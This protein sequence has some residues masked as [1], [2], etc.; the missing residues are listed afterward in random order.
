MDIR[1]TCVATAMV[2]GLAP[3]A[4]QDRHEGKADILYSFTGGTDG[5]GSFGGLVMDDHGNLYGTTAA[6]GIATCASPIDAPGCGVVFE[7]SPPAG[8]NG[9]WSETVLYTFAGGT[10]GNGPLAGLVRDANGNLFGTTAAGGSSACNGCGTVF[11]ISPPAGGVGPWTETVLY[12][13][14]ASTAD[15]R[16]P[17]AGLVEDAHGNLYGTTPEGGANDLGTVFEISP[18]S[19]GGWT[20]TILHDFQKSDGAA[21]AAG[22]LLAADGTLFG[23]AEEGTTGD[24]ACH[25][26]AVCGTVFQLSPP[27]GGQGAWSFAVLFRFPGN[28]RNGLYPA[29]PL[30]QDAQG[31]LLGTTSNGG[32][33]G[34][35]Q[36]N[37][38]VF[39]LSPPAR[40]DGT[41]KLATL[42]AFTT[43]GSYPA[44]PVLQGG[45]GTLYGTT[46]QAGT[47]NPGGGLVYALTPPGKGGKD[48]TETAL[49]TFPKAR[50]GAMPMAGVIPDSA[51]RLY[52]TTSTGG[53]DNC[54]GP[55]CG[56]VYRVEPADK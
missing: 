52:G 51:G 16:F 53:F 56:T 8:K 37:G 39:R 6:G 29:A 34:G 1:P 24:K 3:A 13:F 36:A 27:A 19:G 17:V 28:G 40:R 21:P 23:T 14:G 55:F 45:G 33:S 38:T 25:K 10:D 43:E 4:A 12:R 11:E 30:V 49:S 41:W 9:K 44:A 32:L 42:L 22:L 2:L 26:L 35:A 54:A 20:E 15:G 31:R 7:I 5:G 18:Q 48:W 47:G 46:T 50:D